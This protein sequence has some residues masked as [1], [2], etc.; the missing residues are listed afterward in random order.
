MTTMTHDEVLHPV[1]TF[2]LATQQYGLPIDQ[3]LEV[4]AMVALTT[5]PDAPPEMM[6]LA[7]RHGEVLTCH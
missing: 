4:A 3:V 1:L 6:G 5:V 7:N 2:R